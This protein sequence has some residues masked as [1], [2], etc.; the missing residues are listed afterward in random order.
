MESFAAIVRELRI[1]V[2]NTIS[3]ELMTADMT[4][5]DEKAVFLGFIS[6]GSSENMMKI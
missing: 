1:A 5:R 4:E 3:P 2:M 6:P